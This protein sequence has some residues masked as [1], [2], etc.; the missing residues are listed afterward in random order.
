MM[1][2]TILLDTTIPEPRKAAGVCTHRTT[3]VVNPPDAYFPDV[4]SQYLL[5]YEFYYDVILGGQYTFRIME[6]HKQYG[7]VVRI[8]PRE[9][10]FYPP[11]FYE[12]IYAGPTRRRDRW[13]YYTKGFG[14][15]GAGAS[16]NPHD[17]HKAR[18]AALSPFF[19]M[20]SVRN[21]QAVIEE[22]A[23]LLMKRFKTF[24]ESAPGDTKPVNLEIAFAAYAYDVVMEYSFARS[25]HHLEAADFEPWMHNAA[26]GTSSLGQIA[27]N[28]YWFFWLILHIPD[29]LARRLDANG[30]SSCPMWLGDIN[31][32]IE[33][34]RSGLNSSHKTASH[35]TI[36]HEIL[37]SSLPEVEKR[38]SR[39]A[40]EGATVVSAGTVTTAWTLPVTVF[41]LLSNPDVLRKLKTELYDAIPVPTKSTP[42]PVLEQLPYL[43]GVIQEGLRLSY[44]ICTRLERIAPDETLTFKDGDK[45]WTVPPGT[46]VSMTSVLIHQNPDIFP[47][48]FEYRPERWVEN[49]RLDKY[50]VAFSKGKMQCLGINLAYA[51]LYVMLAKLFRIYG[52]QDVKFDGDVGRLEL[53][54]TTLKDVQ[55]AEDR[56]IPLPHRDSKG[57]RI[58]VECF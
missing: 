2:S 16:T 47:Q 40:D 11:H 33:N 50:L 22:K 37:Y 10:H 17:L 38:T 35:P 20:Q 13:E 48:P 14:M 19:S 36:F 24:G 23:N 27:K 57:V 30:E 15:P 51:E 6:L 32:Q 49:P 41:H 25:D 52:S 42:L 43:T 26:I 1:E 18:R 31:T 54:E 46:P 45:V 58:V 8:N 9:L 39:L 56:F 12:E 4:V 53:F 3:D 44:G 21:L 29:W 28:M 5:R 7:P 55:I 34:I